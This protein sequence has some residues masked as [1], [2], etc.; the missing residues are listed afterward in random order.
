MSKETCQSRHCMLWGHFRNANKGLPFLTCTAVHQEVPEN[1]PLRPRVWPGSHWRARIARRHSQNCEKVSTQTPLLHTHT[2][3]LGGS[4]EN[5]SRFHAFPDR[6][7]SKE[8]RL[9]CQVQ[10]HRQRGKHSPAWNH[11]N[12]FG[13]E[14]RQVSNPQQFAGNRIQIT[15]GSERKEKPRHR[16]GKRKW[17]CLQACRGPP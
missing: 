17:V 6:P 1:S 11:L 2:R 9:V 15:L 14:G 12:F 13:E 5:T 8:V 3:T 16:N 7:K 4:P 10:S